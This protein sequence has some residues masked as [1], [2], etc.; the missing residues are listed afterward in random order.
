MKKQDFQTTITVEASAH[1]AFKA[2]N[3]I[4]EWW[5]ED[6]EGSSQKLN[7]EFTVRFGNA[8]YSKQKLIEFIP[9]KKVTWLVTESKLNFLQ[10]KTEWTNTRITFELATTGNKTKIVFTHFGLA[11]GV[12]CY[13]ECSNAWT[14]YLQGSLYKFITTGKGAPTLIAEA[15]EW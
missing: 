8:H 5:T 14:Q 6:F 7:D 3:N 10:D 9:D 13:K 11:P 15:R 12:E 1:E 4:S 2:I